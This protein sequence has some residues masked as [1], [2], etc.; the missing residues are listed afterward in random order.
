MRLSWSRYGSKHAT[1]GSGAKWFILVLLPVIM[2]PPQIN[3]MHSRVGEI[4][5]VAAMC[6][7]NV[8]CFQEAWS[9]FFPGSF[10]SAGVT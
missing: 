5:E 9:E 2:D 3:A 10:L 8:V 4:L 6:G 1:T 7:V